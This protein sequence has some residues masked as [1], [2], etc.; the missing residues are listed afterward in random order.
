VIKLRQEMMKN[1]FKYKIL[2]V[3]LLLIAIA[4]SCADIETETSGYLSLEVNLDDISN[5]KTGRS[6]LA[7]SMTSSEAKTILAVLIPAVQ[8]EASSASTNTEYS[9]ALV[10]VN[11]HAAQFL[12]PLETQVKLCL[13][14]YRETFSLD[15]L[16]SGNTLTGGLGESD[17]FS[18]DSETTSKTVSVEYWTTKYSTVSFKISS[19]SS[20]GMMEGVTGSVILNSGSGQMM[21]NQSFTITAADTASKSVVFSNVVYNTYSY[22]IEL[23]GFIPVTEAFLV[24]SETE[25][26][27]VKLTPN[28][29][30]LEWLSFVDENMSIVQEGSSAYAKADGK[31]V[32]NV[33]YEQK[34]NVTQMISLMQVKRVGYSNLVDVTPPI[35]LSNWTK[36]EGTDTVTYST[37]F[38]TASALPLVHGS[39]EFQV[40]ITV[41]GESKTET[42]G[43]IDYDACIDSNTMCVTLSWTDGLDPDLHSYYFPDWSYNEETTNGSFDITSRGERYWIYSNAA[44]KTYTA[45]GSVVQ[46]EDG[47]TDNEIEVQ[48]WATDSQKLGNGTYLVYVEDVSET[49]VQNFKLIL[50]GPGLSENVTYGPY[51][52]KDDDNVLTT[53]ALNPQAVF[54][55]QVENNSIVRSD[56]ITLGQTLS[57]SLMQWTGTLRNSVLE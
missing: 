32:L 18:I 44:H 40:I 51:D 23:E 29:V 27:D 30:K 35:A 48:V 19:T 17:I 2:S 21:D 37:L 45:T 50:S 6:K 26:L 42:M 1:C 46:L 4:V 36:L 24:S 25:T 54:F 12:V 11:T 16:N 28:M 38:S 33:P 56:K 52:F 47:N 53:E 3:T 22:E 41:N 9:R 57:P 34:D 31:L 10:D 39:N 14:F 13:Y 55:I 43:K 8:C 15:D 5:R 7:E 20:A 49:D